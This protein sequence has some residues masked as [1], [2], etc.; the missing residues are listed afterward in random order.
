MLNRKSAFGLIATAAL[1]S[2][3]AVALAQQTEVN[4]QSAGNSGVASG[5]GNT[6][7]QGVDQQSIQ[8]QTSVDPNC[9]GGYCVPGGAPGADPQLQ[10]NSQDAQNSGAAVGAGNYLDQNVNQQNIQDQLDVGK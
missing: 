6:V 1:L 9:P 4:K 10:I 3:P 7:I 2:F 5:A 8:N